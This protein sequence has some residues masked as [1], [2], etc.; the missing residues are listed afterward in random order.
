MCAAGCNI[1]N[2]NMAPGPACACKVGFKGVIGW[3]GNSH[4]GNCTRMLCSSSTLITLT[5]GVVRK[6]NGN[7][8]DSV[9]TFSCKEGFILAGTKTITCNAT[10]DS[11]PWP[12][13]QVTPV[14]TGV[15]LVVMLA[16][17][18]LLSVNLNGCVDS[19]KAFIT[20]SFT[21]TFE[22]TVDT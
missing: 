3:D 21:E 4:S 1:A 18:M 19:F 7:Q 6:T 20:K 9:A 13:P 16:M 12:Q 2:S 17:P 8:H 11:S 15:W 22:F 14:C 10:S 5:N